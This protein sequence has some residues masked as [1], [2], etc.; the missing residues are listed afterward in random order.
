VNSSCSRNE[1]PLQGSQIKRSFGSFKQ[2]GRFASPIVGAVAPPSR[3][4]L[5]CP[6]TFS[7]PAT[8]FIG[9]CVAH[10]SP[11]LNAV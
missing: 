1:L 9:Y 5:T 3:E 7:L 10:E 6:H 8:L 4:P 2:E 11:S